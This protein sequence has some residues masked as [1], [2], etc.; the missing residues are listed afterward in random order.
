MMENTKVK[1]VY[2]P[3]LFVIVEVSNIYVD[4][5]YKVRIKQTIYTCNGSICIDFNYFN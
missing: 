3:K 1:I 5:L 4:F 2:V